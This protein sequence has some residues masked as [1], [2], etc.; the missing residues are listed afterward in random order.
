MLRVAIKQAEPGMKLARP[1][2]HPRNAENVLLQAG[3]ELDAGNLHRLG[4]LGVEQVWVRYPGL[5]FI[6]RRLSARVLERQRALVPHVRKAFAAAQRH[7]LASMD[8]DAYT[9]AV[10]RLVEEI[11]DHRAA[12]VFMNDLVGA[13]EPLM[14]HCLRT[15]YLS[16]LLGLKLD[17][18][19]VKQRRRLTPRQARELTNLGLGAMLHD[20]GL[21]ALPADLLRQA[22]DGEE[23]DVPE[24]RNHAKLGFD[25]IRD[26]AEPSARAVVLHHHQHY[27]GSGF[28]LLRDNQ[29]EPFRLEGES[30]HV[31]V[32]IVTVAETFDRLC[33]GYDDQPK[34]H[35]V[36]VI[37]RML[38]N[39]MIEWFDPV[40]LDAFLETVPPFPPGSLV[41]LTDG[42]RAAV[43]EH[44]PDDPCR[45]IVQPVPDRHDEEPAPGAAETLDLRESPDLAILEAD[46][47]NVQDALF[48]RPDLAPA[49]AEA[50]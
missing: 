23:L 10:S 27:D 21:T 50:H 26:Q 39:P 13:G 36:A 37:A 4:E 46:G 14:N 44:N 47:V 5:E 32:R 16:V 30:I 33:R 34:A 2:R 7:A 41:T 28:P 8:M 43:A 18:Y 20:I 15:S 29:G 25:M 42:R 35:P 40:V 24:W 31:F 6:D 12:S 1:V 49:P 9:N 19:L 3:Y 17:A 48:N 38:Q 22:R 11:L 45:P